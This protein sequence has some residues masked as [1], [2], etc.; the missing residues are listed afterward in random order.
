VAGYEAVPV[1]GQV[2][3]SDAVGGAEFCNL[4]IVED[5]GADEKANT[6]W[7]F[8]REHTATARND[9]KDELGMLPV[10]KLRP[11]HIE[12]RVAECADEHVFIPD[13]EIAARIAHRRAAIAAA[14]GL[15][16]HQIAMLAVEGRD[17][18][19]GSVGGEN[20]VGESRHGFELD[21]NR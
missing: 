5:A 17:E 21:N 18:I 14:P 16:E 8:E 3:P 9:V 12:G 20:L 11:A 19:D 2:E 1:A 6:F 4:I 10:L 7:T 13:H 15:V